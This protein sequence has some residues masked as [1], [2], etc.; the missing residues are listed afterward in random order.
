MAAYI[1]PATQ[2]DHVNTLIFRSTVNT[3][4][5]V[6]TNPMRSMFCYTANDALK[7][8]GETSEYPHPILD[9]CFRRS[10]ANEANRNLEYASVL[11]HQS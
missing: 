4:S 11:A 9:N 5:A 1:T 10:V 6:Y 7:R 2:K 8:L 3:V